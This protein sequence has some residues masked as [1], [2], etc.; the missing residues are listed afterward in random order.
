MI[1]SV[2]VENSRELLISAQQNPQENNTGKK[3]MSNKKNNIVIK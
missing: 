1:Q 2:I 3:D